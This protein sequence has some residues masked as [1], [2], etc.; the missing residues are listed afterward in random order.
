MKTKL[1][2]RSKLL[3]SFC[4]ASALFCAAML[5]W[6]L[7][8]PAERYEEKISLLREETAAAEEELARR[9]ESAE[10]TLSAAQTENAALMA[11]LSAQQTRQTE[12]A[13]AIA[14]LEESIAA[15]DE[16]PETILALQDEYGEKIRTLEELIMDGKTDTKI[17][18]LTFDDGPNNLTADILDKL[19]EYNIY[20]TFFTIGANSALGQEE[21][22]RREMMAGHTIANHS[23]NH[24][25]D[26]GLYS[27]LEAFS[28]QVLLQDEFVYNATGFH[29]EIFR[30]PSGSSYCGFLSDASV[31]LEENGFRW[32]DW[33]AS[34]WDSGF[35]SF[36]VGGNVI[37]SNILYT[38]QD[39]DIAV[40][41]C[42]D[43]NYST[44][45]GMDNFIPKLQERGYIFLPL[46][47]QS[48]MFDAPLP[49]V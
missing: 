31:W 18:Y 9:T 47:T 5:L 49:V 3:W 28:Q 1:N 27:S 26:W 11:E 39:L 4:G 13:A 23:Y 44:Y 29:T 48:H 38:T 20:A 22:L 33:N 14:E 32:I 36:D 17:C 2:G 42:H 45:S 12:N 46:F 8:L 43:F 41:L 19:D 34:A 25:Y 6:L 40:V 24:A 30:F 16:L 7:L 15:L 35:H 37:T 21:N 10:E